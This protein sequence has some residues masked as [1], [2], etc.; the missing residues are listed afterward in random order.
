MAKN[1]QPKKSLGQHFLTCKWVSDA[2]IKTAGLTPQD[3]VIEIGPGTGVLTRPLAA[4]AR[5]VIAVEK[6]ERLAESLSNDLKQEGVRNVRIISGDILELLRLNLHNISPSPHKIV[7]NIPY[8][9]TG[10]LLRM[11][12]EQSCLPSIVVLTI[13]KEVA[14]RIVAKPPHTNLLAL[15]IQAF[16][17]PEIIKTVPADCFSPKP[18]VDS[19]IIK[20][21]DISDAFF[22]Q[23]AIGKEAFFNIARAA[24][25]HKR[26]MLVNTLSTTDA[27]EK[28]A[29]Q[30]NALGL[31]PRARPEELSLQNW[32]DVVKALRQ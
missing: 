19:A 17:K 10:R 12:F 18:K 5:Q 6:D 7:A 9:L 20:I 14:E 11:M 25:G 29:R 24:F 2:L 32:A 23:H 31:S 30:L 27:K 3:T 8:Y 26:K 21:S 16:G 1:I 15:S 22:K 13:Q 28:I 4:A